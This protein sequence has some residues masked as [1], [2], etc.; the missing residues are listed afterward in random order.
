V[1]G[2]IRRIINNAPIKEIKEY[3]C[4]FTENC[5]KVSDFDYRNHLIAK[6]IDVC[7]HRRICGKVMVNNEFRAKN[8]LC[9][10]NYLEKKY[11]L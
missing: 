4:Y 3:Y 11:N 6:T 7:L 8:I 10:L 1:I 2:K 5:T 9:W